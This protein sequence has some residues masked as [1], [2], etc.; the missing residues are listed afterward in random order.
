MSDRQKTINL[1]LQGGGAHGAF[2]WGVLDRF[3]EDGR[4]KI[5]A[6]SG[7]SAGAINAVVLADGFARGGA[8][9]ARDRLRMLWGEVGRAAA[10]SPIQRGPFSVFTGDW[11]LDTSLGYFFFDAWARTLSPYDFNPLNLNPLREIL[12]R[13]VDFEKVRACEQIKLFVSATNVETGRVRIFD[14]QSLTAEMV[15]ASACIPT[16]F[17][18]VEI[19]GEHYWDGGYTGNPALFPFFY[20]SRSD[21]ILIVQINPVER[22]GV[23]RSAH[24]IMNRINEI[25]FNASLISE[26]RAVDFVR[27]MLGEGRL[28]PERYRAL[29]LHI[30]NLQSGAA[31]F[32]AA[33]K[34]NAEPAFLEHLF[35]IGRTTAGSWLEKNFDAI[36]ERS[37]ADIRHMFLGDGYEQLSKA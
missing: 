11:S 32:G 3:L 20:A 33:T 10:L 21:D 6:I 36:G 12:T 18:A 37:T 26:L 7:T 35:Q 34:L 14:G 2:T 29:N 22:K 27:R 9:G 16:L 31:A 28:D 13:T 17:Q 23:P 25:S 30:I 24:E 8:Q 1:A 19:D 5:E 4:V 15:L